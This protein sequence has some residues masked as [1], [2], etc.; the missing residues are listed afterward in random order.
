[1]HLKNNFDELENVLDADII[2]CIGCEGGANKEL[3][4][5]YFV[6]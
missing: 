6:Y 3:S 5:I 1:M 4:F 2:L